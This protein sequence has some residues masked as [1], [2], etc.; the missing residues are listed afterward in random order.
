MVVYYKIEVKGLESRYEKDVTSIVGLSLASG[1]LILV[2]GI[3][4]L[5]MQGFMPMQG[6]MGMN[7]MNISWISLLSGSI[8]IFSSIML[9]NYPNYAYICGVLILTFSIISLFSFGGFLIGSILGI[10]AGGLAISRR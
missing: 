3:M 8:I 1:A 10:I 7:F 2:G 4:P 9:N 5:W 6:M